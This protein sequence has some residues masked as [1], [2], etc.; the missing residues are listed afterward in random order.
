MKSEDLIW[1]HLQAWDL[2]F[3]MHLK[4]ISQALARKYRLASLGSGK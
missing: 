3:S 1:L 2:R 4:L